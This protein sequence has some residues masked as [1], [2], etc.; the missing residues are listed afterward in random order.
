MTG[1]SRIAP[2]RQAIG[3]GALFIAPDSMPGPG[4]GNVM[5]NTLHNRQSSIQAAPQTSTSHSYAP[6]SVQAGP[7]QLCPHSLQLV[8]TNPMA[9]TRSQPPPFCQPQ[10]MNASSAVLLEAAYSS[11]PT[12]HGFPLPPALLSPYNLRSGFLNFDSPSSAASFADRF[13]CISHS[14]LG[15]TCRCRS[16]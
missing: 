13:V 10:P 12:F 2:L 1:Y 3:R 5:V 11:F 9:A 14:F 7:H 8:P 4:N 15:T 16:V 6:P